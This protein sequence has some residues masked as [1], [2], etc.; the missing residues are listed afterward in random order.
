MTK[1]V[2]NIDKV[3]TLRNSREGNDP[4]I[5]KAATDCQIF[6]AD[7][8]AVH[9][10]PDASHVNYADVLAL[11]NVVN[12]EFH[13]EGYPS[14][15]FIDLVQ[16][17]KPNQVTLVPDA[18]NSNSGWNVDK[19]I[20]FLRE[21]VDEMMPFGA[22]IA[23]FIEP[24]VKSVEMAAKV[25]ADRVQLYMGGYSRSYAAGAD[26]VVA[27]YVEAAQVARDA[28][29]GVNAGHGLN[30]TNLSFLHQHIT[31]LKEVSV[32][33]AFVSDALYHGFEKTIALYK[34]CLI[35]E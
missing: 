25:G 5:L 12:S 32:G 30:L 19:H 26:A 28:G 11:R 3:A 21:V 15:E 31:W 27:P 6:G 4:D 18:L 34:E 20:D 24:N 14:P 17:A 2:I 8:I 22:R 33:H 7:A 16:K 13:I 35:H 9:A 29:L 23:L 10:R 1:L